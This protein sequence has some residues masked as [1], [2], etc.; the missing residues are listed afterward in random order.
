[1]R[2]L[3]TGRLSCFWGVCFAHDH[4][5]GVAAYVEQFLINNPGIDPKTAATDARLA[6]AAFTETL[7]RHRWFCEPPHG[8]ALVCFWAGL[9]AVREYPCGNPKSSPAH[10]SWIALLVGFKGGQPTVFREGQSHHRV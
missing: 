9:R 1:L 5:Q 2:N 6:V 10:L 4:A 7:L 3:P 8:E